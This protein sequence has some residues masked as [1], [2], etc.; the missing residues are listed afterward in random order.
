MFGRDLALYALCLFSANAFHVQ[1]THSSPENRHANLALSKRQSGDFS[2]DSNI[3]T[4]S[5]THSIAQA[6]VT[7]AIVVAATVAPA[8]ADGNTKEFKL[9]PIDYA[10]KSRC[11]LK[12]SSMGQA[13]AARDKLYDLRECKIAGANARG[14]DLSGVIM[15]VPYSYAI[16]VQCSCLFVVQSGDHLPGKHA[17][18]HLACS[19]LCR[20]CHFVCKMS[21]RRG[22]IGNIE[23]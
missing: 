16:V 8:H 5:L 22:A 18:C 3:S 4:R 20:I 7:A 14:F 1:R 11:V 13:N 12:S 15:Y 17:F 23:E 19:P 2:D 21:M 6:A 9:P 10:D